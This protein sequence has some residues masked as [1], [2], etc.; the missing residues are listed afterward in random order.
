MVGLGSLQRKQ[1]A[2][3]KGKLP[4]NS[5]DIPEAER[6]KFIYSVKYF[7]FSHHFKKEITPRRFLI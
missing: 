1:K 7:G 5:T 3:R 4:T 2:R 6:V